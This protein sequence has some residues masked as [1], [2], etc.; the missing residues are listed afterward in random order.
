MNDYNPSLLPE[1]Y[2]P[3]LFPPSRAKSRRKKSTS[4]VKMTSCQSRAMDLLMGSSNVFITGVAGTGKTFLIQEFMRSADPKKFPVLSSTG[5]AA[6]LIGGRT[7]HSFF[8]LGILEGGPERTIERTAKNKKTLNRIKRA[9]GVL[10]DEISMISGEAFQTAEAIAR[11]AREND[12][13][14][15]GLRIIAVGDFA[16]LPPVS[17]NPGM[18]DWAFNSPAWHACEFET[19]FLRTIVRTAD[20]ELTEIL[21]YVRR[22]ELSREVSSFLNGKVVDPSPDFEGTRL[23]PRRF[24]VEKFNLD[25]LSELPSKAVRS[26][27]EYAG[28]KRYLDQLKRSAPIPEELVLKEGALIM[29][30]QNDPI[31]RWANGTLGHVRGFGKEELTIELMSGREIRLEKAVFSL[32]DAEGKSVAS[33]ENYP[34]NLAYATTIHKSQGMTLDRVLIDLTRLW[35][36]GQAYVALSRVRSGDGLFLT[37]WTPDSIRADDQVAAFY[38]HNEYGI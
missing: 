34:V 24:S 22:G 1:T 23:F 17:R 26:P 27:T 21:D 7:F 31:G 5:A 15:G 11:L 2:D 12:R 8:G 29:I 32:L 14:W 20:Q 18:R 28:E 3:T 6:L 38:A 36:P 33:A 37:G 25:K 16:Q 4:K 13:P 35:E 10:I 30:R 9:D 19:G